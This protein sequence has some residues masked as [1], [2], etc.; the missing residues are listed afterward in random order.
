MK[1]AWTWSIV[2]LV[3]LLASCGGGDGDKAPSDAAAPTSSISE[4]A[5]EVPSLPP[6]TPS[7]TVLGP[8]CDKLDAGLLARVLGV[9]RAKP[10]SPFQSSATGAQCRFALSLKG[11]F[12][13]AI[14]ISVTTG[15]DSYNELVDSVEGAKPLDIGGGRAF[16]ITGNFPS[17][18]VEFSPERSVFV[19]A[20]LSDKFKPSTTTL[21][22]VYER[23]VAPVLRA[24]SR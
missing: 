4:Q 12:G 23:V 20:D 15:P 11:G 2:P 6:P 21:R 5:T 22:A 7:T 24:Q 13:T 9:Q 10:G 18:G 3:A 1:T 17:F 14:T 19:G 8:V 16:A